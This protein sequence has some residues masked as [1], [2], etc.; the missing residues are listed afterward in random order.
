[1]MLRNVCLVLATGLLVTA[2]A[3]AA[4]KKRIDVRRDLHPGK[5][6]PAKWEYST[7]GGKTW[8]AEAAE[9]KGTHTVPARNDAARVTFT[10]DDPAKI[11]LL[12]VK[13]TSGIGGFAIT[14]AATVEKYNVP[15]GPTFLRTKIVLNG[16][17]TTAGHLPYTLY[18]HLSIDPTLL[19]KG[20]NTLRL[21]GRWWHKL[22]SLGEIPTTL[23]LE[24]MPTDAAVLERLPILGMIGDDYFGVAARAIIPSTFTVAVTPTAPAGP[25][26]KHEFPRT[27]LLKAR[28]PLPTGTEK[29]RYTVT[30]HAGG[31]AKAYGPY[32]AKAPT[33]GVGFRFMAAG[34]TLIYRHSPQGIQKLFE[35]IRTEAPDVFI[36]T[37]NYQNCSA[38]DFMWTRSFLELSQ[39]TLSRIPI[40]PMSNAMDMISPT[41]FSK[42]FFFPPDDKDWGHW[43]VVIGDVRFVCVE[44]FSQAHDKSGSGL[45]WLEGVLTEAKEPYVIVLNGHASH[46]SPRNYNRV[47]RDGAKYTLEKISPMLAKY[48]VTLTI[49]SIH[50]A[51]ERVLPPADESV[52][53]ILTGYAGGLGWHSRNKENPHSKAFSSDNHYVIFEVKKSGL[54]MKAINFKGKVIDTYTFKPRDGN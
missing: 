1:M 46:C 16:K 3:V 19:E 23:Q 26:T 11:G 54:E 31:A 7:D 14:P 37:G 18:A 40:F 35:L 32:E 44:A 50:R 51:Y 45:K 4:P 29:F 53:T 2:G 52:P 48:K 8:A 28:V 33:R 49:G 17:E 22:Y 30:V 21:S 20:V 5:V 36:H 9:I 6:L 38:W 39:P 13:F 34:G 42:T 41:S 25:E 12:K 43:T 24:T 15:T 47:F 27:R 10:I